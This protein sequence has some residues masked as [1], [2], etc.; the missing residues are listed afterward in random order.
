MCSGGKEVLN[1]RNNPQMI[2][3]YFTHILLRIVT[4]FLQ[5]S[6]IRNSDLGLVDGSSSKTACL[7]PEFK[8]QC[9]QKER[10][11]IVI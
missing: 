11:E 10:P 9:R 4:H 8:P 5:Q 1:R 7:H 3:I 6:L 2:F